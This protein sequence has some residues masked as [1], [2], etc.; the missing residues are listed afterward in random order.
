MADR[1]RVEHD[2]KGWHVYDT[3]RRVYT[4]RG[5][6]QVDAEPTGAHANATA[7]RDASGYRFEVWTWHQQPTGA[8]PRVSPS[9]WSLSALCTSRNQA[10]LTGR[11]LLEY[12]T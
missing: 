8:N 1:Y 10:A 9:C 11:A 5:G 2:A 7:P 6:T 4:L 3:A 12:S